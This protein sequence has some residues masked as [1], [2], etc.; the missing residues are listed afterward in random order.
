MGHTS[1]IKIPNMAQY[2]IANDTSS[3]CDRY[4]LEDGKLNLSLRNLVEYKDY[5]WKNIL[6]KENGTR[7][8]EILV[9]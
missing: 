7:S 3:R 2:F 8:T 1:V 5:Q 9:R 6:C 4:L